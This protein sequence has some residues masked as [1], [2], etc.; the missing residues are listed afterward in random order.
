[1]SLAAGGKAEYHS[2]LQSIKHILQK[3]SFIS[4]WNGNGANVIRVIPNY[5]LR[6][7]FNDKA[8]EIVLALTGE[9]QPIPHSLKEA[10]SEI[11]D[12][13]EH[14]KHDRQVKQHQHAAHAGSAPQL[15]KMQLFLAGSLAGIAQISIT[16][17]AEVIFT[18]LSLSG[19]SLST[20]VKYNG[21]Y[22]SILDIE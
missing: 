13:E 8:R 3:E 18:R 7:S 5:G 6:F 1:M 4:L 22:T 12:V 9:P 19:S 20:A 16:Y 10:K 14:I 15:S 2:I 21:K 17:P 11:K